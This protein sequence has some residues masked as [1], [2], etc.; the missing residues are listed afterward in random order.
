MRQRLVG[1]GYRQ[2]AWDALRK[3]IY[4]DAALLAEM[5]GATSGGLSAYIT[6]LKERGYIVQAPEGIELTRDTGPR[7]PSF[8]VGAGEFRDWNLQPA[9]RP[10]ELKAV[11][12]ESGLTLAAWLAAHGFD[13][14][15]TTRLRQMLN[16]QRPISDAITAA[17][18]GNEKPG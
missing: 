6:A 11:I 10:A 1:T 2:R 5:A 8:N 16:G 14:H 9:M 17:A 4:A 13:R 12:R 18:K 15:N 3:N 7:A